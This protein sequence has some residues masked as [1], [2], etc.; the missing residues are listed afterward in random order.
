MQKS[1]E[2][3]GLIQG[4]HEQVFLGHHEWRHTHIMMKYSQGLEKLNAGEGFEVKFV[5]RHLLLSLY[6]KII[7]TM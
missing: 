3:F 6:T 2:N 4:L 1:W 5:W 7:K